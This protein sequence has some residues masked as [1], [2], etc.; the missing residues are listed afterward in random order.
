MGQDLFVAFALEEIGG[1]G[2]KFE[3]SFIKTKEIIIHRIEP[4]MIINKNVR[5]YSKSK[6]Q[7]F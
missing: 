1:I 6:Y 3:R 5:I 7:G 4:R 2:D